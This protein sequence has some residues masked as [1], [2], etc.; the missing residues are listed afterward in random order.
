MESEV[1]G[2]GNGELT[3]FVENG[4][5]MKKR[6]TSLV[7]VL[8][9][10]AL[11]FLTPLIAKSADPAAQTADPARSTAQTSAPVDP[12]AQ[13][14][15]PA[16]S[17][18]PLFTDH[19]VLQQKSQAPVWGKTAPGATVMVKPSWSRRAR[20]V[21]ADAEGN[22]SLRIATPRG[23][24]KRHTL[25]IS[26]S[27]AGK[28]FSSTSKTEKPR[29][30]KASQETTTRTLHDVL[31]GEV[32]FS[33]GQ[34]N[35]QMPMESWRA[36]RVNQ[37]DILTSDRYPELRILQL[38]R[39]TGMAERDLFSA[40]FGGWQLSSARTVRNFSAIAWY[41]GRSLQTRLKVPVGVIHSSWGGTVIEAWM[42]ER[43]IREY[44]EFEAALAEVHLLSQ[45]P[46]EKERTYWGEMM[47]LM[48]HAREDDAGLLEDWSRPDTEDADWNDITLPNPV[49]TLWPA[50]NGVFWYRKEI[51]I[52][53]A[54]A[55]HDLTLSLGP[56]DD[57]DDTYWNGTPVGRDSVWNLPR[58]YTVP[59]EQVKPGRTVIA[60]RNTDDHGNGGLYGAASQLYVQGP[61]GEKIPLDNN[62]K[63][64]LSV[65]FND[66]PRNTAREPNLVTVLYNAMVKPV[67]PY[68]IKGV[69]WYQG[70]SNAERALQYRDLMRSLIL[71]WR[72]TWGSEFPFYIT[73][74]ANYKAVLP[75]PAEA[76]WAELREA[77]TL[78][79]QTLP[80]VDQAC[81]IDLGEA[82]DV[83]P[84]RKEEAG[85][86]LAA[87]ALRNDYGKKVV[88]NGPRL[89]SF[90][91][92]EG[93]ITLRFGDVA[94]GLCVRT[95]GPD[96]EARYGSA[97]MDSE[98]VKQAESGVLTGFQI[99]GADKVWHWAEA[100]I[101][102]RR[103]ASGTQEVV[104][105]SPEVPH[106]LQVRYGWAD[107]PVCNLYNSAGL[108]A[109]PFRTDAP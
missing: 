35:M 99:A 79:T 102:P 34:S 33:A 74:I 2:Q 20:T 70:E 75:Q 32:W 21:Q 86:R 45:D 82:E 27:P 94:D 3:I 88:C 87:L 29:S 47:K 105:S 59:A 106:P 63:V 8:A 36:V 98:L 4:V 5:E 95:D 43:A 15:A 67:A 71:D 78:A 39:D 93:C 66:I 77:Q 64:K 17:L 108:P 11:T 23:S 84:V 57:F 54:W 68:A 101:L 100:R 9:V 85:E 91:I 56:I 73:Q 81:I 44:P 16:L 40:D 49:Q 89:R 72:A 76:S 7:A 38:S 19:M 83:H 97:A 46:E 18:C 53:A 37:E 69:I 10:A 24:Y 30:H 12:A 96:A 1:S 31:V 60:I 62:W 109:W 50:T 52:P 28:P 90:T 104:I 51:D 61:D 13:T 41:F 48:R 26:A 65:S 103:K 42:S 14:A 6:Y 107:N 80:H 58:E 55:G 92:G 25:T 22:W